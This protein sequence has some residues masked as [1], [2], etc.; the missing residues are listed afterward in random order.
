MSNQTPQTNQPST[1]NT[2]PILAL[3]MAFVVPL[4]GA[5]IGHIAL[6]QMREGRLVDTNKGLAKA[7][8][9]VGWVITGIYVLVTVLYVGLFI[10][11]AAEGFPDD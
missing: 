8:L 6:K 5:I 4:V 1:D 9:I 3:V 2:L 7:G 10:W 11:W